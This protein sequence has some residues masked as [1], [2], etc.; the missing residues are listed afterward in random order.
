MGTNV[1]H[2]TAKKTEILYILQLTTS[3]LS[4]S[5]ESNGKVLC[6]SVVDCE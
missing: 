2:P 5:S 1:T 6:M 3:P 4:S